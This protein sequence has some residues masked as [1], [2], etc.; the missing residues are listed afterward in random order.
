MRAGE[1]FQPLAAQAEAFDDVLDLGRLARA[2]HG[3]LLR[4]DDVR[5][6]VGVYEVAVRATFDRAF[7]SHQAVFLDAVQHAEVFVAVLG[8]AFLVGFGP[9]NVLTA[10]DAPVAEQFAAVLQVVA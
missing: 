5:V 9:D 2:G 3:L 10:S 1:Q 6:H 4:D 7:D 8:H